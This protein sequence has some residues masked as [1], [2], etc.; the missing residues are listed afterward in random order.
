[1]QFCVILFLMNKLV[2]YGLLSVF[3]LVS[4]SSHAQD[5]LHFLGFHLKKGRKSERMPI[6]VVNNLVILPI[7]INNTFTLNFI[8]DS[9]CH[10]P[11]L[12]DHQMTYFF[13]FDQMRT[14]PIRGLGPN[15]EFEADVVM[16]CVFDM[17][18]VTANGVSL[19]ILP[20][21]TFDISAHL[22]VPVHGIIGYDL[23]K[24][25]VIEIDYIGEW[26]RFYHPK[27]KIKR[28][29]FENFPLT[30]ENTKPFINAKISLDDSKV[31]DGKLMLDTGASYPLTLIQDTVSKIMLPSPNLQAYLGTGL[32]GDLNGH[33]ARSKSLQL[34]HFEFEN[35]ITAFPD[36]ASIRHIVS[37]DQREGTIGGEI[38]RRFRVIFDYPHQRLLLKKNG[39]YRS[40]FEYNKGGILIKAKGKNFNTFI[41]TEID[42]GSP[43]EKA[44]LQKGDQI[45]EV[46]GKVHSEITLNNIYNMMNVTKSG[47]MVRFTILRGTK[48]FK[49]K[50]KMV[51][52]I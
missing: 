14:I 12:L 36:K 47:R 5:N 24:N 21:N 48:I 8:L 2:A 51:S 3:F 9:G 44:K 1:M 15:E 42:P 26:I 50:V 39:R 43:A 37:E 49:V 16:N 41:I 29:G 11:I 27:K 23:F 40:A 52:S 17:E 18:N 4:Y 25:F 19:I 6:T 28:R 22:G 32:S 20:E 7:T 46:N 10:A 13:S 30:L 38:L 33:I 34:E 35:I 31:I 45:I